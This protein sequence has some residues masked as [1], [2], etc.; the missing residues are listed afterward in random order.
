MSLVR[1]RVL[2]FSQI[3]AAPFCGCILSDMGADVV[4]VESLS[5]DPHRNSNAVVPGLGKRFQSLNRGK[6]SVSV[7]LGTPEA[8]E[9][10][11][12]LVAQADR[13]S[14]RLNSSH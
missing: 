10:V 2:E 14:T 9:A 8:R 12:R 13:K 1:S 4:K 7:D 5:G 3:V 11:Y 6:R